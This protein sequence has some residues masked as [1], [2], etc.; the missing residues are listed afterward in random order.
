MIWL[1]AIKFIEFEIKFFVVLLSFL[2]NLANI[3]FSFINVVFNFL[4]LLLEE[5]VNI[6]GFIQLS[7]R[8]E[9]SLFIILVEL[10]FRRLVDDKLAIPR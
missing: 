2:W 3:F 7:L 6:Q 1:R 4:V 10:P 9:L 5:L 8:A